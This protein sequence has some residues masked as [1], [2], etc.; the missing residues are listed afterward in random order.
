MAEKKK[1][2]AVAVGRTPGIYRDWPTAKAQVDGFPG[3]RY[4]GFARHDQAESWL[5]APA[6]LRPSPASPSGRRKNSPAKEECPVDEPLF[7]PEDG[8][9][10]VYTDGGAIGNPGPGGYGAVIVA[11]GKLRELSGGFS[12]TTNN[13]M[14]LTACIR[15]LE[16][17]GSTP[18]PVRLYSDSR[19]VVNGISKGWAV[20]WRRRG[21]R[22]SDGRPA[23]NSDLWARLLELV[24]G[25]SVE[26]HWVR[27]HAGN[28]LN[29]RCD[30]LAQDAARSQPVHG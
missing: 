2:Y 21:W 19:Y 10:T 8:G 29:E 28:P 1:F 16:E 4:K 12:H 5:A 25:L 23:L 17:L 11:D 30:A 6:A 14:E 3:A 20:G 15:A 26:F 7:S 24:E 13:R 9:I 22:K 18:E 27:G